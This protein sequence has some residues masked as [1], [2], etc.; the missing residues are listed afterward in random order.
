MKK[1]GL[2]V[3]GLGEGRSI[4]SAGINSDLWHVVQLCDVNEVKVEPELVDEVAHG[5]GAAGLAHE[6][7]HATQT[8]RV[9][10]DDDATGGRPGTHHDGV[11][12]VTLPKRREDGPARIKVDVK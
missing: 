9:K 1:L 11:L 12:E 7:G 2:G 10:G 3:L 5:D 4:I 8:H 6:H